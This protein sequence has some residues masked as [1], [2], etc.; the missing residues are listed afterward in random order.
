MNYGD[1][2]A[3]R[4]EFRRSAATVISRAQYYFVPSRNMSHAESPVDTITKFIP[5]WIHTNPQRLEQE[6]ISS[7]NE[8]NRKPDSFRL[9]YKNG[10]I[11]DF[12]AEQ[13]VKI[14]R[15]S[16]LGRMDGEF[17]DTLTTWLSENDKGTAIWISPA[18]DAQYP[19]NK[20]TVYQIESASD[21]E[22]VTIN[23][24]ILFDT[25]KNHTLEIASKINPNFIGET[26]PEIL[27]N[28]LFQMEDDFDLGAIL[29]IISPTWNP[30]ASQLRDLGICIDWL[31][32]SPRDTQ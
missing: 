5:S 9:M 29:K 11:V 1:L 17:F 28:K 31:R 4:Q 8:T 12:E 25:P 19:C 32:I 26:D 14:D 30:P 18:Y 7:F 13:P 2:P 22:K 16:Y 10:N 21:E 23:M 15:S 6:I 3:G 27:R 20:I 24:S